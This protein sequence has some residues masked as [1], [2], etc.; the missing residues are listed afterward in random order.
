[1]GGRHRT[2]RDARLHLDGP[3]LH[4]EVRAPAEGAGLLSEL[5]GPAA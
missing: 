1:M 2:D 4:L 3:H 5:F